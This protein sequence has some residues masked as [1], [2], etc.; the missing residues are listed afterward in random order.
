MTVAEANDIIIVLNSYRCAFISRVT[1]PDGIVVTGEGISASDG[2]GRF[3]DQ[4]LLEGVVRS[5]TRLVDS[6]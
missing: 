6:R 3:Y 5:I 4:V 2:S 1:I